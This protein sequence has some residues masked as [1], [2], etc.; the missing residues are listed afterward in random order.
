MANTALV[1]DLWAGV[2]FAHKSPTATAGIVVTGSSDVTAD[3]VGKARLGDLTVSFCGHVGVIVTGSMSSFV[4][5]MPDAR[6]GDVTVG[7][8][9][10]TLVT[11][12]DT[13]VAA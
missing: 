1:G 10:G 11:S 6:L 9:V 7:T 3:G 13:V 4:N 5:G 2:C 8:Y 12:A